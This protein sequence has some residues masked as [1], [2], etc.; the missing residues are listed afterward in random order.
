VIT[1]TKEHPL[2]VHTH[3]QTFIDAWDEKDLCTLS[4]CLSKNIV[5]SNP[6]IQLGFFN[7][8]GKQIIGRFNVLKFWEH[9]FSKFGTIHE[10]KEI[11]SIE[12]KGKKYLVHCRI[13]NYDLGVSSKTVFR[14]NKQLLIDEITFSKVT[15]L[16]AEKE[17]SVVSLL[18]KQFKKKIFN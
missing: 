5:Y 9:F 17:I 12:K 1:T 16:K 4:G 11:I 18:I 8:P 10:Q 15:H 3:L 7:L 14:F 2:I 13:H 6:P